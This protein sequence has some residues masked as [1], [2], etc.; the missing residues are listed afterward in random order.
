MN[1]VKEHKPA[2]ADLMDLAIAQ[3]EHGRLLAPPNPWVGAVVVTETGTVY[4]GYTQRPGD[5]HAERVALRRAG[6]AAEGATLFVTLE[7]CSHQG[8]TPPCVGPIVASKVSR[9]V[10]G[11]ADPDSNVSGSG[12][13]QLRHAG[14]DVEVGVGSDAIEIQLASYLHHRRTGQPYVVLKSAATMDGRTAAPDQT[15]QWIT[16][17]EARADAHRLR[18]MSD[19]IVVG[20]GTVRADNPSLTVR[21]VIAADNKPPREPLR[22]VL[23]EA[24]PDAEVRPCLEH[25]GTIGD[26]LV[27]LGAD[28]VVSVLVEGGAEVAAQF[29]RAGVVNRYVMYFAPAL[30]GGD[31][32][33]AIFAG[34]GSSTISD[35][36]RG[37]LDRVQQLGNDVRIDILPTVVPDEV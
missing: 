1:V 34:L 9:V 33:R 25:S 26:L 11:I 28:G 31:D 21:G 32:G 23:G 27:R 19:A 10:V 37:T 30:M 4:P 17:D 8:R 7:P 24:P 12:I 22:V 14:I 18:A 36:F 13:E 15:S 35:V 3:A 5:E 16:G 20:A 2:D 29:H 6:R